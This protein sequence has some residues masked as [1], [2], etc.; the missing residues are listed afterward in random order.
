MKYSVKRI[1]GKEQIETCEKFMVDHYMWDS[2]R[3]PKVYGWM[4]YLEGEGLF[5]KMVCEE[6]NPKRVFKLHTDPVYQDSTMEAFLAFPEGEISNDCMY[7]NFEINSNGAMLA[8]FGRGWNRQYI[9]K[10]QYEMTGVHAQI[11]ED[12]WYWEVLFPESYLKEICDFESVKEGKAFYCNFYKICES[13]EDLH[14]GSY[15]PIESEKPNFHLP[16]CF[17]QAVIE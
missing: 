14:F 10:E 13:P 4:G 6:T 2:T 15:S 8:N 7:T 16:V 12:K 9:S 5:V 11:E 1:T 3:E 17:A